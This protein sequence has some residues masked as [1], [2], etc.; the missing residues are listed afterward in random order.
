M[1]TDP[2]RWSRGFAELRD[3]DIV[4]ITH[5]HA[6]HFHTESLQTVLA[7]N[8]EATVVTN[9]AVGKLLDEP[10]IVH[11]VLEG[12]DAKTF[13]DILIEACD[14]QHVEIFEDFGL[15]QNTGYFID[16]Q[17]FYPGDAYTDPGKAVDVLALPVAG[18]W[19]KAADAIKYALAI[20]PKKAFPVHDATL[21][22]DGLVL[23]H[24]LFE[25]QLKYK[26]ID[27]IKLRDGDTQEF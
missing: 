26:N 7:N 3:I 11:T 23:T 24:G 15:V 20:S 19:C 12:Q 18:P 22:E 10:G 8:P 17:L 5:E 14:G 21:S 1:L 16:N 25:A 2:G 4:L 6:D 27:F 13:D 9:S